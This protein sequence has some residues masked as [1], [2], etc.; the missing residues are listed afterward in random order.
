MTDLTHALDGAEASYRP[1]GPRGWFPRDSGRWIVCIFLQASIIHIH[2][3]ACPGWKKAV[4]TQQSGTL[5][6]PISIFVMMPAPIPLFPV[7]PPMGWSLPFLLLVSLTGR[8]RGSVAD[9]AESVCP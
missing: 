3:P 6:S 8:D 4:R 9:T 5:K 1:G 7:L 2:G